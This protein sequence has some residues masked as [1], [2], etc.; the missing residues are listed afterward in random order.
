MYYTLNNDVYLVTGKKRGCIY[1]LA[2]ERLYSINMALAE[3]IN[4]INQGKLSEENID[5]ELKKVFEKLISN[6][7]LKLSKTAD[8]H[9]IEE[10]SNSD[11]DCKFAWIEI[12]SKCNLRC[13]HCYNESDVHCD[14]IMSLSEFKHVTNCLNKIGVQK[15]QIIGGEPF[16]DKTL[17]KDMLDYA[18]GKFDFIEIFTNG[19]LIPDDWF[20]Y[21]A[22]YDIHI[23]LSVY[24]YKEDMH[25]KVTG[26]TGSLKK[27][28]RTI[29]QLCDYGIHYRVCNVLMNQIEIGEKTTDLYILREDKDIVRMS[30]R[31]NFSLLSDELIERKLITKKTFEIPI[32]KNFCKRLISGHNCFLNKI[33]ISANMDVFPCVMERRVKHCSINGDKQIVLDNNIQ[34]FT[35]D[36]VNECKDCEYR[37]ACFDCRPNSLSENFY[38]KPWYCTYQPLKGEWEETGQ[39]IVDLKEKWSR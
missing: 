28:N 16:F 33:Y 37:Y 6:G 8:S 30:G 27:T 29:Q 32:K 12:T 19:T 20:S 17:L 39:F 23:A 21:L 38:E 5:L 1:D 25:D 4:M 24:S 35:K 34:N 7:T 10:I 14:N 18:I 31:A 15:I 3:K 26:S 2:N 22:K 36:K 11:A 9:V 13:I